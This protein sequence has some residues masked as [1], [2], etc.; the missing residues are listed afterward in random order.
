MKEEILDKEKLV[1]DYLPFVKAIVNEI[2]KRFGKNL[3]SEE[4]EAYGRLGLIEAAQ[5]FDPKF[6]CNFKTYAYY[7][8]KGAILDALRYDKSLR[9]DRTLL[10]MD[11]VNSYME[12]G[13]IRE[14][15][16]DDYNSFRELR[17]G[18]GSL[19]TIH[20]LT[21][22]CSDSEKKYLSNENNTEIVM[23]LTKLNEKERDIIRMFYFEDASFSD[24]AKKLGMSISAVS[25]IH[26]KAI[27]RLRSILTRDE[28]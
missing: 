4:L 26:K 25:R 22:Y 23:S 18:I 13:V 24:I 27:E 3:D 6:S 9:D 10:Y 16:D 28:S 15:A 2:K 17:N 5:R 7:R 8:V 20:L 19:A 14:H 12:A 21:E 11:G 1:N